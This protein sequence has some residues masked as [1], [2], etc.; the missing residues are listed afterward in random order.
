M[1]PAP[2]ISPPVS[3]ARGPPTDWGELVQV[4][5]DRDIFQASPQELPAIVD[6]GLLGFD[7]E[8][9]PFRGYQAWLDAAMDKA[10]RHEVVLAHDNPYVDLALEGE[11]PALLRHPRWREGWADDPAFRQGQGCARRKTRRHPAASPG[12]S[13]VWE[14]RRALR[15]GST[16]TTFLELWDEP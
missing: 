7:F 9:G 8:D 1:P 14:S 6:G 3:P 16:I 11:A 10:L 12:Q 5:D 4:H 13:G 15:G 2:L